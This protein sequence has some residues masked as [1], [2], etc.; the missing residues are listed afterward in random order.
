MMDKPETSIILSL[1][2]ENGQLEGGRVLETLR[3]TDTAPR[4]SGSPPARGGAPNLQ[5][6]Y[7]KNKNQKD[8]LSVSPVSHKAAPD[9]GRACNSVKSC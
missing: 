5:T 6:V 9:S 8:I 4:S 1:L 7:L 2:G 3:E